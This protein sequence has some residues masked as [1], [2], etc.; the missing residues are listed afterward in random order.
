MLSRSRPLFR[1]L[2][3]LACG[4]ALHFGASASSSLAHAAQLPVFVDAPGDQ[5][6]VPAKVSAEGLSVQFDTPAQA[7]KA[8]AS[9]GATYLHLP[10]ISEVQ[11]FACGY[12]EY[13]NAV[14]DSEGLKKRREAVLRAP[15]LR[16]AAYVPRTFLPIETPTQTRAPEE[17]P[18]DSRNSM[19]AAE[20]R[21][22]PND[23]EYGKLW[24][25]KKISAEKA[26]DTHTDASN[27]ILFLTD[28]GINLKH[29]D[30][31]DNLWTNSK[32]IPGNGKDDDNNGYVDDVHG[33]DSAEGTGN[34]SDRIGHGSHCACTIAGRGNNGFG[35][36]GVA[37]KLQIASC[38]SFSNDGKGQSSWQAKCFDYMIG[39]KKRGEKIMVTNNSWGSPMH[40]PNIKAAF[41]AAESMGIIHAVAAGN[42]G[43]N[44]DTSG[45]AMFPG[46]YDL[47]SIIS[48]VWTGRDDT[49]DRRSNYGKKNTDLA[50]PGSRVYSCHGTKNK[51]YLSDGTSMAAPHVAGALALMRSYARAANLATIRKTLLDNV[52]KVPS[53]ARYTAT[54]GR[55]NVAKALAALEPSDEKD[56]GAD[57]SGDSGSGT[58]SSE[59][60][61]SKSTDTSVESSGDGSDSSDSS[62]SESS[63]EEESSSSES[64][65]GEE[66]GENPSSSDNDDEDSK[67]EDDDSASTQDD[68]DNSDSN[69]ETSREDEDNGAD[70]QQ[71]FTRRSCGCQSPTTPWSP[72]VSLALIASLGL[73]RRRRV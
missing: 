18:A 4:A 3:P 23:K 71:T 53:L 13:P 31:K 41:E 54:G 42:S 15:G 12:F 50:A 47:E 26:W 10:N 52:D 19:F 33:I 48:V 38:K 21:A 1:A 44:N 60:T 37:W 69:D 5:R 67:S 16:S 56:E 17:A 63:A 65:S 30:I 55:L 68:D 45:S 35:V 58:S 61:G 29:S 62:T 7:R 73:L 6:A 39:L 22:I 40:D 34:P 20:G 59:D 51:H 72:V 2:I 36:A 24:G 70:G 57:S 49:K 11:G 27:I 43:N 14:R 25:M 64:S 46:S 28:S 66:P 9:Q 32:E 8:A